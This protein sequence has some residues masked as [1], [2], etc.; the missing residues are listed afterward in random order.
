MVAPN[1]KK[2]EL[3][4][5]EPLAPPLTWAGFALGAV[6]LAACSLGGA[7]VL[8]ICVRVFRWVAGV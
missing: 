6:A 7:V 2:F 5:D 3:D 1:K 4:D 8:G